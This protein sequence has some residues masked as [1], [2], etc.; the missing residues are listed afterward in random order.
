MVNFQRRSLGDIR[1]ELR[2]E[3][4]EVVGEERCLVAGAGDGNI[5]EARV[6]Q[7]RVDG[8]VGVDEDALGGEAL[9]AVAGDGVT[10]V[11]VALFGGVEADLAS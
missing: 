8:C 2:V 3:F 9:G 6:E 4:G 7:V 1:A 10:V 5:S 11:E